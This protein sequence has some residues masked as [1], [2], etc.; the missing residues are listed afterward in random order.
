[1]RQVTTLQ[2]IWQLPQLSFPVS[3][4][5]SLQ[6]YLSQA[7]EENHDSSVTQETGAKLLT[8]RPSALQVRRE[9]MYAN[10]LVHKK[11]S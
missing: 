6:G 5:S 9:Q 11:N 2:S 10:C 8:N 4:F 7:E 1:M 3:A